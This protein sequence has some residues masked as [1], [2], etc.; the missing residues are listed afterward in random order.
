MAQLDAARREVSGVGRITSGRSG[1]VEN[2]PPKGAPS[3]AAH[4]RVQDLRGQ[5]NLWPKYH[6]L[7]T[8][9]PPNASPLSSLQVGLSDDGRGTGGQRCAKERAGN[10]GL[11]AGGEMRGDGFARTESH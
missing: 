7:H 9:T 8:T 4:M 2:E 1:I 3:Q 11:G 5:C 6:S 10:S